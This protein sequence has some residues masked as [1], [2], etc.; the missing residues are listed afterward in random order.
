M[1]P[2]G[3]IDTFAT[4]RWDNPNGNGNT[5]LQFCN[6]V[7]ETALR[8]GVWCFD[9]ASESGINGLNNTL[10][11]SDGIHLNTVG[12]LKYAKAIVRLLSKIPHDT[13][14]PIV[15]NWNLHDVTLGEL[16]ATLANISSING[17]KELIFTKNGGATFA[18]IW[19]ASGSNNAAEWESSGGINDW[20][21]FGDGSNGWLATGDYRSSTYYF[22][23]SG[24]FT[25][26]NGT[27]TTKPAM[28]PLQSYSS[29][30]KYRAARI[31]NNV[32]YEIFTGGNWVTILNQSITGI[33]LTAGYQE[34]TKIGLL[35]GTGTYLIKNVRVG[36]F[37]T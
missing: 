33:N 18:S 34:N 2:Y 22:A 26:S 13:V 25:N 10:Y 29:G 36:T 12:G 16:S 14:A 11:C 30:T 17:Q 37:T 7:K 31:G 9:M 8:C 4:G 28:T 23:F 35:I 6:A 21:C 27:L 20:I 15:S 1:T 24:I 19:L 3:N 5:W 32:V